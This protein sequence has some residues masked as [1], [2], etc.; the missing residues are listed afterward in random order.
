MSHLS[1]L[2]NSTVIFKAFMNHHLIQYFIHKRVCSDKKN[3]SKETISQVIL[4]LTRKK[5][6]VE[7]WYFFSCQTLFVN[8]ANL[9]LQQS[10]SAIISDLRQMSS[11]NVMLR[12]LMS[13]SESLNCIQMR[14]SGSLTMET[15]YIDGQLIL[16]LLL[17]SKISKKVHFKYHVV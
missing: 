14:H 17:C 5:S 13:Q 3:H 15:L 9:G 16:C 8:V 7:F 1:F 10:C 4:S 2:K 11:R 6:M 12:K